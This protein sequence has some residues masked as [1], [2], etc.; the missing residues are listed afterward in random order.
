MFAFTVIA[1]HKYYNIY[2]D[3]DIHIVSKNQKYSIQDRHY[4]YTH[5]TL[6]NVEI[7][8]GITL[9]GG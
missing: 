7:V 5:Y 1:L 8:Y 4:K 3:N 2:L 9:E 6:H